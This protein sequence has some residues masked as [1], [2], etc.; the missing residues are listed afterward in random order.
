[1]LRQ[2]SMMAINDATDTNL[3]LNKTVIARSAFT[4]EQSDVY[5]QQALTYA[6]DGD[7]SL[8]RYSDFGDMNTTK[9]MSVYLQVDLEEISA[10]NQ[11]KLFRYYGDGRTYDA[12]VIAIANSE[13]DF[14]NGNAVIVYNFGEEAYAI[15]KENFDERYS[16]T[17]KGLSIDCTDI[18]GRYVRVY[19]YGSNAN[20]S[21]RNHIVELEVYG[22]ADD[23]YYN[24]GIYFTSI[25]DLYNDSMLYQDHSDYNGMDVVQVDAIFTN[26]AGSKKQYRMVELQ[27]GMFSTVVPPKPNNEDPYKYLTFRIYEKDAEGNINP[28]D[29]GIIYDFTASNDQDDQILDEKNGSFSLVSKL[30]D[31]YY[32]TGDLYTSYWSGHPSSDEKILDEQAI[33]VDKNGIDS[34]EKVWITYTTVNESGDRIAVSEEVTKMTRT[35]NIIYYLFDN[36]C[37]VTE[38]T[39]LAISNQPLAA[40]GNMIENNGA[41]I[42]Y[43]LYNISSDDNMIILRNLDNYERIWGTYLAEGERYL[44]FRDQLYGQEGALI[45]ENDQLQYRIGNSTDFMENV[46][47]NM[48]QN[49]DP[50]SNADIYKLFFTDKKSL[51]RCTIF[52]LGS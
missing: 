13:D 1:M 16:E 26:T 51:K 25:S 40:E 6:V 38:H 50:D 37:G 30:R 47:T 33:Y 27:N 4:D 12:T 9:K 18:K 39:L 35:D 21:G 43:F 31:C 52:N 2:K 45:Q 49:T 11:I 46:W 20:A 8:N 23:P 22:H 19:G 32:W 48:I 42:F 36:N 7:T 10:V 29:L 3:A 14:K 28:H 15:G 34:W 5:V 24:E 44:A 17:S 41:E